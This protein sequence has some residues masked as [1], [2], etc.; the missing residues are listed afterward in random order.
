MDKQFPLKKDFDSKANMSTNQAKKKDDNS[1]ILACLESFMDLIITIASVAVLSTV[2]QN[3]YPHSTVVWFDFDGEYFR[4]NTM[5]GFQKEKNIKFHPLVNLFI[6]NPNNSLR[7]IE[8]RG[9]VISISEKHSLEHL[10]LLSAKYTG[11]ARYFGEVIPEEFEKSE[12]PLIC[13]IKPIRIITMPEN[14]G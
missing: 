5:K 1:N 9:E 8:I 14:E 3:G 11:K 13:K 2:S 10:N 12:F 7:S 4:I 6:Y